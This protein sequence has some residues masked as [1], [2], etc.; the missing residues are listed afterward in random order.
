MRK[1]LILF[2]FALYFSSCNKTYTCECNTTIVYYSNSS[3]KFFTIIVAGNNVPYNEKMTEKKAKAACAH[4]E[5]ATR[6]NVSNY[7]TYNGSY[8]LKNG[9]SITT[10]C[11]LK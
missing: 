7:E 1:I 10:S 11:G 4:E 2:L 5:V 8:V 9:E 3:Q 6:T